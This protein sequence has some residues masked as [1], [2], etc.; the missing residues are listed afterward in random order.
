LKK[1]KIRREH[2]HVSKEDALSSRARAIAARK[3]QMADLHQRRVALLEK[4]KKVEHVKQI[5]E[6]E[7]EIYKGTIQALVAHY[8]DLSAVGY[9]LRTP[10]RALRVRLKK[11]EAFRFEH[12]LA[13]EALRMNI[14]I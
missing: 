2:T 12:L 5:S 10:T 4:R 7:Y 11:R 9:F 8:G 3:A 13:A 1:K 14:G 6:H